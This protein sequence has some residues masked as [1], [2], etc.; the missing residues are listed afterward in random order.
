MNTKKIFALFLVIGMIVTACVKDEVFQ[1]PPVIS[2]LVLTPQA[3][4]ENQA[5]Q[6]SVKV[7]DLNGVESVKLFYKVETGNYNE[8]AMKGNGNIYTAEIPGQASDVT[9]SYYVMATNKSGQK[10]FFPAGAP[11]TTAAFTVGA[12]LIVM[13]EIYSRGTAEDP[14]WIEIYNDSDVEV[15]ISGYLIYDNGVQSGTKQKLPVPEGTT[16]PAKGFYVIVV[17]IGGDSGFGL[18]SSGEEVWLE[19]AKGNLIDNV[20]FPALEPT[21]S[22]GRNPDGAPNW[23]V[24][25]TVTKGAPNSPSDPAA[26]IVMNEIY[27]TGTAE[28]P[29][30]IELYNA[31]DFEAN[32]GGYKIYDSGGQSGSKPKKEIPAGTVIPAK[33]WYVIV[34]DDEDESGF[35]LSSNGEEVWLENVAGAIID[36]ITFPALEEGQSYGRFPDGDANWQVLFVATPAAANDDSMPPVAGAVVM[37]EIYSNGTV[38]DPDW[39]EVFN[40]SDT[41]IDISGYKIYDDKGQTG[42]KPKKEF[43]AGSVIPAKGWLVIV[44]D[45]GSESGFG[46][47][48]N[49][50]EVW[51][52]NTT[53]E[54]IDN[55]IFPALEETQSYGRFPD[56]DDNWQVLNFPTR[57]SA[58]QADPTPEE[59]IVHWTFHVDGNLNPDIGNG[60]AI[61]IGGVTEVA[62]DSA[63]RITEFPEQYEDSG[64]AGLKLLFGTMGYDNL[65]IEFKQRASG[66]ASRWAELQYTLNGGGTWLKAFDNNG[67][68]S[69]HDI[70]YDFS[71]DLSEIEGAADNPDFGIR[72]VSVFSPIAF[73][74]GLGNSFNSNEAYHR[75]IQ[76]GGNPY[77]SGGNWR[78]QNVII[79]GTQIN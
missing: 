53:G 58:N 51:L 7:T 68:L 16:I 79:R 63:L 55:I 28:N 46:L 24:L 31:S 48:S 4:A 43:P 39:I 26:I 11:S 38:E 5:V 66:T 69:P 78:F 14:D 47:S 62:Q 37:N 15:D 67:G 25:N 65:K 40:T 19:N 44:V 20:I 64:I 35:G 2:D 71:F 56:G 33:G 49:G 13:N 32:I 6:V 75:A 50:E 76:S 36:N 74:D 70:L 61:L 3:P 42:E 22:Y 10:T 52:E 34:V 41:E 8:V 27:S 73:E 23:E 59:I 21:Q 72:I 60:T 77:S 29:D 9:I 18:S 17:D 12:P 45:D 54:V 57:G 1:G 30:W